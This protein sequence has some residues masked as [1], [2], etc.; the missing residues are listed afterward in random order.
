MFNMVLMLR[1]LY[2]Q[3]YSYFKI[4][5]IEHFNYGSVEYVFNLCLLTIYD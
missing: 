2:V 4:T 3:N 5:P 1:S